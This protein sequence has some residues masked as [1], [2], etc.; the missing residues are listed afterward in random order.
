MVTIMVL[1]PKKN[2]LVQDIGSLGVWIILCFAQPSVK[3]L[4][5][6]GDCFLRIQKVAE[7]QAWRIHHHV[8]IYIRMF[9][10]VFIYMMSSAV[11][12]SYVSIT[13]LGWAVTIISSP[14][15]DVM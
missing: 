13:F 10:V 3:Y 9:H 8:Y 6:R 7:A 14:M 1:Q 5:R 12:V 4:K 11:Y 2:W 15:F